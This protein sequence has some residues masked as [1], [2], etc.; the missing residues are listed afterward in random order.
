M[1]PPSEPCATFGALADYWIGDLPAD[2]VGRIEAHVFDCPACTA[3]L[4]DA[5]ALTHG[6]GDLVR[7]G[8]VHATVTDDLLNRLAREG[9]RIR[10]YVL[11]P[12][13]VVPCGVWNDDDVIVVR[14]RADFSGVTSVSLQT[15]IGGSVV[16]RADDIPVHDG[17]REILE[18]FPAAALR[19]V[20][21]AKVHLTL[22]A[23]AGDGQSEA[24]I[25]RYTLD[26]GGA[27]TR[28]QP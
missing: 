27:F 1:T 21:E 20:P 15:E 10:T 19:N 4:G 2:D 26:H 28:R 12:G 24:P 25:A 9:L 22:V 13:T 11:E 17:T 14:L 6:I 5:R 7:S 18:A 8:R 23:A 3:R 16:A